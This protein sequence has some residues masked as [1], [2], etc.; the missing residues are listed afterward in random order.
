MILEDVIAEVAPQL[1]AG[2]PVEAARTTARHFNIVAQ[3]STKL[4][5]FS[6]LNALLNAVLD[7]D[8]YDLAATLLWTPSA[9]TA[10]PHFTQMIFDAMRTESLVA[11]QGC[12][13]ASKSFSLGVWH[14]LDWRRD[15]EETNISIVGPSENHLKANL[16]SHI[17]DLHN[18]SA[19]PGPGVVG[20]LRISLDPH[21]LY[22]GI[23]GV[24]VPIGARSSGRLQGL[25]VK[26]RKHPHP[27]FGTQTRV[28]VVLEE[29]ENIQ[30]GVW[31]D[32]GNIV[33]NI[34]DANNYRFKL[35][36][37]YNP[38]DRSSPMA[39]RAEPID[40]W[41]SI[42][43]DR[44]ET[45]Q[46]RRGWKVLR[47]DAYRCENVIEGREIYTG[48]QTKSGMEKV[49]QQGGGLNT[50]TYFTMVRG[51][52]P[53]VGADLAVVPHGLLSEERARGEFIFISEPDTFAAVDVALEG[54]DNAHMAVGRAGRASGW[55]SLPTLT[56][57]QGDVTMFKNAKGDRAHRFVLQIEQIVP[58]AKGATDALAEEII[59]KSR[60][61]MI[62]PDHLAVDRTGN[63]AGVHDLLRARLGQQVTG[64][65][66]SESCTTLK[67]LEDD[68]MTPFEEYSYLTSEMYFGVK[69]WLDVGALRFSSAISADPLFREFSGRRYVIPTG[70]AKTRV[71]SKKDYKSRGNRSPDRADSVVMLLQLVRTYEQVTQSHLASSTGGS[72]ERYTPR[73]GH[74]DAFDYL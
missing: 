36:A 10:K 16:F 65:N 33:T 27:K 14:Y 68:L 60:A 67:I 3:I 32:V 35:S 69:K 49:I 46:S 28:R 70:R 13:S 20:E 23:R 22:A 57:P 9:F 52:Y 6:V 1:H 11:I 17:V 8:R 66:G 63:G 15:P 42:D 50:P 62:K 71:E 18:K 29:A 39:V 53:V 40:G 37:A 7:A 30:P 58:L 26:P 47:L 41:D 19:I 73:I 72:S 21:D 48:L 2:D 59:Q 43:I 24:V 38:K 64:F 34:S 56:S 5:A 25:K 55:R 44:D 51:F 54:D 12:A 74:T 61:L 45:W 4:E 31:E